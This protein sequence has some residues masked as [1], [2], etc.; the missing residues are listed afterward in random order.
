[1]LNVL[2]VVVADHERVNDHGRGDQHECGDRM[3][4]PGAAL[5]ERPLA[6]PRARDR[7]RKRAARDHE[8]RKN[9][10]CA[11]IRHRGRIFRILN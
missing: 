8:R 3:K 2:D 11:E 4:E 5:D 1:M 6:A 9:R 7:S 10:K